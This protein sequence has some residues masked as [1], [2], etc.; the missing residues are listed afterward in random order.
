MAWSLARY[1]FELDVPCLSIDVCVYHVWWVDVPALQINKQIAAVKP[2][3]FFALTALIIYLSVYFFDALEWLAAM[4]SYTLLIVT[5]LFFITTLVYNYIERF[6]AQG[7]EAVTR[8]YLLSIVLKLIAGCS[9]ISVLAINDQENAFGNTLLFLV[10][11]ILFTG[12]EVVF[13][14]RLRKE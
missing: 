7:P 8:F 6:A 3:L 4:P 9:L 10:S 14:L 12:V 2:Y 5:I 1:D 11:Y 13:L